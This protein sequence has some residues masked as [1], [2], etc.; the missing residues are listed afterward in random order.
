MT[1]I[2]LPP[3]LAAD[4]QHVEQIVRERVRSRAAVISVAGAD[5]S[6]TGRPRLHATLVLLSAAAGAY[7]SEHVLHAAAAVELILAATQ[8]HD[9]LVDEAGRRRDGPATGTWN[10]GM[11]LMVGDYLF[12]LA[13][14]E[15]ALSPDPRVITF[16]SQ[17]VMR[18]SEATLLPVPLAPLEA[19]KAQ[20]IE[21]IGGTA[22][23]LYAAACRAG[24]A[25]GGLGAEA[26]EALGR[27]G[28]SLGLALRIGEELRGFATA[29]SLPESLLRGAVT[30]PLI[31]AAAAGEGTRL[32]A[33]LDS[34]DS[35]ELAWATAEVRRH[36]LGPARAEAARLA[37]EARAALDGLPSSEGRERLAALAERAGAIE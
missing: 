26:I 21:R 15:M 34:G 20:H 33:A 6:E 23:A 29:D 9:V 27:Y 1:E 30:L 4:L 22:A 35:A 31:Y 16:F 36:G 3:T 24:A 32:A 11:A 19:A 2:A 37:Q 10:H 17:A 12:A 18:I 8:T 7:S 14:G 28:Y 5:P 13:S 25:C